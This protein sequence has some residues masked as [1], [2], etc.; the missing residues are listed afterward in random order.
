M[1]HHLVHTIACYFEKD[2]DFNRFCRTMNGF[3]PKKDRDCRKLYE[4]LIHTNLFCSIFES[5]TQERFLQLG[6]TSTKNFGYV[7]AHLYRNGVYQ[8]HSNLLDIIKFISCSLEYG[9]KLKYPKNVKIVTGE[10]SSG[11]HCVDATGVSLMLHLHDAKKIHIKKCY[12]NYS[13]GNYNHFGFSDDVGVGHILDG[14]SFTMK[15]SDNEISNI[16]LMCKPLNKPVE[17]YFNWIYCLP[18][19]IVSDMKQTKNRTLLALLG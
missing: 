3:L 1:N 16:K 9:K 17:L 19:D 12:F 4:S 5:Y 14:S 10:I 6:M 13:A 8:A 18:R 7:E 11:L 2:K 15:H